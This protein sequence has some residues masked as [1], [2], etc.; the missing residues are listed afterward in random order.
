[1]W[2][3]ADGFY[4]A[5][6]QTDPRNR[7]FLSVFSG[8]SSSLECLLPET[9]QPETEISSSFHSSPGVPTYISVC[10][11]PLQAL[12]FIICHLRDK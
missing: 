8:H 5:L 6:N 11:P 3:I 4:A 10:I 12:Y 7:S 1:M 2:D 9:P